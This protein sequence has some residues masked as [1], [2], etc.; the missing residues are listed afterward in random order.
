MALELKYNNLAPGTILKDKLGNLETSFISNCYWIRDSECPASR[1]SSKLCCSQCI[2]FW[3]P[4][5]GLIIHP[6]SNLETSEEEPHCLVP[7]RCKQ[8]L[9]MKTASQVGRSPPD[10]SCPSEGA[11]A[12]SASPSGFSAGMGARVARAAYFPGDS[13]NV[14]LPV[15]KY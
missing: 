6:I 9:W 11:A 5:T 4:C 10:S 7:T 12:P 8:V 2:Y 15:L 3:I 13:G 14:C 1:L